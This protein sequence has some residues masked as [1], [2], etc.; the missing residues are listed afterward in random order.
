LL[1]PVATRAVDPGYPLELMKQNVHGTVTLSAVIQSDGSVGSVEVLNGIDDQ[2]DEYAR[3]A[4]SHWKFLPAMRNG[5]PVSLQA[6][7]M[8][9]FRPMQKKDGF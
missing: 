7:V 8:I 4:L 5:N 6:V 1:S 2:L 9:P 3:K